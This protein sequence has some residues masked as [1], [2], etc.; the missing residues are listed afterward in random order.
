MEQEKQI[1]EMHQNNIIE[2]SDSL[3]KSPVVL[4]KKKLGKYRFVVDY[5]RVNSVTKHIS[6]P[7]SRL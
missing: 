3:R 6:Q 7:L 5:R 1:N 2:P 4:V